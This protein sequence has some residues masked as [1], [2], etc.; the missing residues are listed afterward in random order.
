MYTNIYIFIYSYS[1][2]TYFHIHNDQHFH[3]YNSNLKKYMYIYHAKPALTQYSDV[4]HNK[5]YLFKIQ[6]LIDLE[7]Y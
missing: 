5:I 1:L 4:F 3:L 6:K 2:I 7:F